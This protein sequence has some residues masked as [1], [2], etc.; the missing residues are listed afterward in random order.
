MQFT[1]KI[2]G[3]TVEIFDDD[4]DYGVQCWISKG[5]HRASLALLEDQGILDSDRDGTVEVDE[6]TIDKIR[7]LADK[8]GY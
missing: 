8:H 6:K 3:Y 1:T 2:D 7:I 4:P 5:E